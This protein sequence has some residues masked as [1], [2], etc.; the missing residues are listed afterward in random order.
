[1]EK[2]TAAFIEGLKIAEEEAMARAAKGDATLEEVHAVLEEIRGFRKELEDGS[3][4]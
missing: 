4:E 1:M 3:Q 2:S